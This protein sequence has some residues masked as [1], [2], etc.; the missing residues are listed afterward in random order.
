MTP[1]TPAGGVAPHCVN[2]NEEEVA[3]RTTGEVRDRRIEQISYRFTSAGVP[4][5]KSR[6]LFSFGVDP[7]YSA[8][9]HT[10]AQESDGVLSF[11]KAQRMEPQASLVGC[12]S[13]SSEGEQ[14]I[15]ERPIA[16]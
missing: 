15:E 3:R 9:L 16:L 13:C 10:A 6:A 1:L 11:A 4:C 8:L 2:G 7:K 14:A 12:A 5:R